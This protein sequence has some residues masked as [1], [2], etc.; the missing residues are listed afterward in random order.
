MA[1][2]L[3]TTVILLLLATLFKGI[4]WSSLIPIWHAPDEQAHFAQVQYYA[5]TRTGIRGG[6]DLS[7]EVYESELLLGTLRNERGVN[8]FTYHPEFK[9][10]YTDN[11]NGLYEK[12]ISNFKQDT[13]TDF[14][15][16]E[17][18]QYPPLFYLVSTLGYFA[19]Y[20]QD[21]FTRVM[22]TRLVSVFI[23]LFT[24]WISFLLG[25][26]LF[27]KND[28]FALT[29]ATG[30][31]F[32]PMYSF[33]S[34]G[35]NNDTLLIFFSTALLF[36]ITDSIRNG[37]TQKK[38]FGMGACLGLGILTKQLI[39]PL[40]PLPFLVAFFDL[41]KAK[42]EKS[43]KGFSRVLILLLVILGCGGIVFAKQW[44]TSGSLPGWPSVNPHSST[45][46]L[47][48]AGYLTEK[49]KLLYRET[50]PWYWGVFNW[51]GVVLPLTVLRLIKIFILLSFIGLGKYFAEKLKSKKITISD[52][53]LLFLIFSSLWYAFW[54]LFWDYNLVK[55][56]GFS[57]GIQGRNFFPLLSAHLAI[58]VF[59][60]MSLSYK[61]SLYL[62]KISAILAI[63][64]NFIGLITMAK[65]YYRLLPFLDFFIQASQYKPWFFKGFALVFWIIIYLLLLINFIAKYCK[66]KNK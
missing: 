4:V 57:H 35:I 59:G 39:Y 30:V 31:S 26:S 47:T 9:I 23:S 48:F 5:E 21:L 28:L 18:A 14:V 53:Q 1:P 45:S 13:R 33:L 51:L 58:L 56:I 38:A 27:P 61:F 41:C 49:S 36:L 64:L 25:K 66:L 40:I 32:Q 55:S 44:F 11:L 65:S 10:A 24:V 20:G 3:K 62:L 8:K 37:F 34:S 46:A 60:I 42:K 17:A 2:K 29:L 6:N 19:S 52:R 43:G 50:L 12:V 16:K 54:L 63:G 7:R 22:T 15:K